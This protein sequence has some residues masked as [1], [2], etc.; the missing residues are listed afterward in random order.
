MQKLC[1]LLCVYTKYQ[2]LSM[3]VHDENLHCANL[4]MRDGGLESNWVQAVLANRR[5]SIVYGFV[6]A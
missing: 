4:I 2:V 1:A 3:C 5:Q 6:E